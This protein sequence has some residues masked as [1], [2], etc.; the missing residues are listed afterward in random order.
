ME[1]LGSVYSCASC[2]D[3]RKPPQGC[4]CS[5]YFGS[6]GSNC[7]TCP[8]NSNARQGA[9]AESD[10]KCIP[11]YYKKAAGSSFVCLACPDFSVPFFNPASDTWTCNCTVSCLAMYV[12]LKRRRARN[13][14]AVPPPLPSLTTRKCAGGLLCCCG[15]RRRWPWCRW[16]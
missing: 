16:L 14:S 10:C 11:G 12:E 6:R 7:K 2:D 8:E 1:S 3:S 9:S 15:W 13:F 5:G 4:D